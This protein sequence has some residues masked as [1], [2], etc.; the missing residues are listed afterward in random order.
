MAVI[1]ESGRWLGETDQGTGSARI[2]TN[3]V[4]GVPDKKP[5]IEDVPQADQNQTNTC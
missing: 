2:R 5:Y 1:A 3:C 4:E